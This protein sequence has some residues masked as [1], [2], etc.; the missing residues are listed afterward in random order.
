MV[1]TKSHERKLER[2]E[3]H[4]EDELKHKKDKND[5]SWGEAEGEE[6][7]IHQPALVKHTGVHHL[8]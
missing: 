8:G 3:R 4:I 1:Q 2:E 5:E 6:H 7:V